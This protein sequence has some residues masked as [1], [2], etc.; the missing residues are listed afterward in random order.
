M[1]LLMTACDCVEGVAEE[2]GQLRSDNPPCFVC[3]EGLSVT[4]GDTVLSFPGQ[5]GATC[6]EVAFAGTEGYYAEDVCATIQASAQMS[7]C[8]CAPSSCESEAAMQC[9]ANCTGSLRCHGVTDAESNPS[10]AIYIERC[11]T[12]AASSSS[13]PV[14]PFGCL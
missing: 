14:L 2:S 9:V 1:P 10:C 7:D 5:E 6:S 3:G 12:P 4:K 11:G 13:S 8:G